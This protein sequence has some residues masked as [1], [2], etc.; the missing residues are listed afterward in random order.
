MDLG[1]GS[2]WGLFMSERKPRKRW[3][4]NMLE[5]ANAYI[6]ELM[7]P[8]IVSYSHNTLRRMRIRW[9]HDS[10]DKLVAELLE[11]ADK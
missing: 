9:G 7:K 3:P 4:D 5:D 6:A 8:C 1:S 2:D 11:E 10:F